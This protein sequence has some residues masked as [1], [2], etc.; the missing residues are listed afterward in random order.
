[1][2]KHL[3]ENKILNKNSEELKK[4]IEHLKILF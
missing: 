4:E 1:M 2:I 3:E